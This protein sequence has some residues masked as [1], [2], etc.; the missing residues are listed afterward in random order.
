[1]KVLL[2]THVFLWAIAEEEK[3]SR[4]A[5]EIYTG[6]NELWLSVVSMWEILVKVR[7]GRLPL[8]QPAGPYLTRKLAQNRIEVLP[9]KLDHALRMETLALHHHDPFDR[10]LI[11]QSLEEKLPL[12]S[13][14]TVFESYPVRL[15]W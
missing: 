3:L 11:A 6:P 7:I 4:R 9:I 12:V 13:A 14:D 8:P 2:D 1:M 15:L 5:R 10:M